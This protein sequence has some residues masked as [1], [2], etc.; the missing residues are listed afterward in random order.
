M[1]RPSS[2]ALGLPIGFALALLAIAGSGCSEDGKTTP[3]DC[4]ALPIYDIQGGA[5]SFDDPADCVT[6]VGHAVSSVN[7]PSGGGKGPT[8][9]MAGAGGS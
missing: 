7:T 8:P 9:N 2:L 3:S 1:S 5:Q 6:D 4:P